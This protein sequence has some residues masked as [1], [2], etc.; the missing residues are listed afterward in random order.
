MTS[1][2]PS[3]L[4]LRSLGLPFLVPGFLL[5][6]VGT[7]LSVDSTARTTLLSQPGHFHKEGFN[8]VGMVGFELTTY[9]TQNRRATR[10]RYTPILGRLEK[11]ATAR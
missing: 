2:F 10:L 5:T 7:A 1:E 4:D 6:G 8:L 3:E 9:G 11:K